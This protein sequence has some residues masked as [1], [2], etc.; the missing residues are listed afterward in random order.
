MELYPGLASKC[1]NERGD[2][3]VQR[4]NPLNPI[5]WLRLLGKLLRG[6]VEQEIIDLEPMRWRATIR[7][8]QLENGH[9]TVEGDIDFL[10]KSVKG[11]VR[12]R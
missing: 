2:K 10:N 9:F 11:I 6:E 5:E 12:N 4:S 7:R 1:D 8:V 3:C